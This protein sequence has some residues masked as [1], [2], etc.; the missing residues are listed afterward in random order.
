MYKKN[1][2]LVQELHQNIF[3]IIRFYIMNHTNFDKKTIIKLKNEGFSNEI[4]R[5]IGFRPTI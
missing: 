5:E 2:L 4:F 1:V 3:G